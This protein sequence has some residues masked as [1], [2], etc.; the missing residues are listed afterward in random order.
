MFADTV[1]V[2]SLGP[3]LWAIKNFGQKSAEVEKATV[4][5]V[6]LR[7]IANKSPEG[8][9]K[10]CQ[11]VPVRREP[12]ICDANVKVSNCNIMHASRVAALVVR[13]IGT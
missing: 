5:P 4:S 13:A 9:Q 10:C 8:W 1:R 7:R 11:A 2:S 6:V 3:R 12:K